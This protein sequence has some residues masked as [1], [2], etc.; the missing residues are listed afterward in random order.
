MAR[1]DVLV[2][3]YRRPAALAVT[4]A[5]VAAQSFPDLRVVVSDQSEGGESIRGAETQAV[6]RLL[7]AHGT[8]V[9]LLRN[10]PRRG[11]AQQRQFLLDQARA[12]LAL[13]LDDD[14]MLEPDVIGRLVGAIEEERCGFVGCGLVGLGF[15]HDVR[16][17]EQAIELWEGRPVRPERV[18]PG[19]RTWH[20]H[21]LHNAANL[22]HVQRRLGPAE[23]RY[24]VAWIGGCVLYDTEKLRRAGGYSFWSDLP[25]RHAGEDV[26]AQLRVMEK[27]GGCGIL[28]SGAYHQELPTT[29]VD[30]RVDATK[31][32]GEAG[33]AG[34]GSRAT[35]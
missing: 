18:R 6:V 15:V 1:L 17:H 35:C 31:V 22:L 20:R 23:R 19:D 25:E 16:P 21:R 14:V 3:T 2:P 29:V 26:L 8:E 34:D 5:G 32:L 10:L 33:V 13:F 27:Y 24:K 4:L 9:E 7:R 28:P 12:P 11:M 30:R